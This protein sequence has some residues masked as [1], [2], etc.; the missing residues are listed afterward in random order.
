MTFKV[1]ITRDLLDATGAPCFGSRALDE[2]SANPAIEWEWIPEALGVITPDVAARYDGLHVN[3]PRVTAESVGRADCRV[4]IIARNGVGYDSVDIPALN[5][6][7]IVLTNTPIA[8][9]RPVA[10]ATLTLL[11]AL[12]GRLIEK[13]GLVRAGR[14]NDR[15]SYMGQGLTGRT[16]GLVGGGGI[17]Q[18]IL[19]LA[20]PF[21][22]HMIVAD[23]Y[24]DAARIATLGA[25]IV[26]IDALMAEADYVVTCCLLNS[27]THHLIDAC[28]FALMKPTAYFLNVGRGP[29]A[30]EK[31]LIEA[32]RR[33]L[34]AGAGL[35]VTE[36]EP[37]EPDNPLLGLENVLITPHA[38]CWTDECFHD[39]A[40]TALRSIVAVSRG[41]RPTHVVNPEVYVKAVSAT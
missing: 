14:W 20:R 21:F 6:K 18:E 8:V 37:I 31:A 23:P 25:T 22:G 35:D 26:P 9:R 30:D 17:G 29:I 28:R 2:L 10:V 24:A 32:L 3:L 15:T 4:K 19:A 11:F 38:L 13:D 7:G 34:I 41:E 12:A 27:E 36:Q 1:G 33:G 39:I 5:A 16:L 40:A